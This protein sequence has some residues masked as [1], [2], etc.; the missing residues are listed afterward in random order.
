MGLLDRFRLDGQVVVIT[1]GAGMLGREHAAVVAEL[2]GTPVLWDIHLG[3][4]EE[5]KSQVDGEW[6]VTC[7]CQVVDITNLES[8]QAAANELIDLFGGIHV[9]IN[10]AANNPKVEPGADLSVGRFE[11]MPLDMWNADLAVGLT[12]AMLCCRVIGH[13]MALHAGGVILNIASDLGVIAPDQRLYQK[14]GV[15]EDMQPVKPV[16]YSVVKHG[17]IGLTRYIATYW[18]GQGVRCN[19]IAP[20]GIQTQ[21]DAEFLKRIEKLIPMKRMAQ[22]DEYRSAVAFLIS[23]A[24]SY[25]TGSVMSIDGGRTAW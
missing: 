3:A 23:D 21:Q 11:K 17:L 7:H 1:G 12:G 2:G 24:S 5:A 9:L 4:L 8:V 14:E 13:H 19:A 18:P 25:M 16:T 15:A 20:G 22:R 6:G 10:N